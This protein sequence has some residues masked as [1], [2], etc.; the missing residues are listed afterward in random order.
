M[1]YAT[2]EVLCIGCC[3]LPYILC[4][5]VTL[6]AWWTRR[7]NRRAAAR[8]ATPDSLQFNGGAE[9]VKAASVWSVFNPKNWK[10]ER[11]EVAGTPEACLSAVAGTVQ[12]TTRNL[13]WL[14][15]LEPSMLFFGGV[16]DNGVLEIYSSRSFT[17]SAWVRVR[18]LSSTAHTKIAVAPRGWMFVRHVVFEL[19]F[20]IAWAWFLLPAAFSPHSF[21]WLFALPFGIWLIYGM[22]GALLSGLDCIRL[23][24]ATASAIRRLFGVQK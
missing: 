8:A 13:E 16:R 5:P 18:V 15:A 17:R 22:F 19:A 24:M 23:K 12:R 6:V 14:R 1:S 21:R 4:A 3:V 10:E 2:L 11:F 9:W 7:R 20:L